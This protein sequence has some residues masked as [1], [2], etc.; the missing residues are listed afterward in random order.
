MPLA[1]RATTGMGLAPMT[2][3]ARTI[4]PWFG[5]G[6]YCAQLS[7]IA[8]IYYTQIMM[9]RL[10]AGGLVRGPRPKQNHPKLI[11]PGQYYRQAVRCLL[12]GPRRM[13]LGFWTMG[14]GKTV[15]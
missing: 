7:S 9:E 10:G 5:T 1:Q 11:E 13:A 6:F 8:Q 15:Q 12:Y 4:K 2:L 3:P 14:L